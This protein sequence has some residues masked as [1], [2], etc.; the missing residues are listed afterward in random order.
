MAPRASVPETAAAVADAVLDPK[1][2]TQKSVALFPGSTADGAGDDAAQ[3]DPAFDALLAQAAHA[4]QVRDA[5]RGAGTERNQPRAL[6]DAAAGAAGSAAA[7]P[8]DLAAKAASAPVLPGIAQAAFERDAANALDGAALPPAAAIGTAATAGVMPDAD[9]GAGET[10][11]PRVGTPAWDNALGQKVV[12]MAAGAEQSASLTLNPP[13]LG[14]LQV[15]I[16]VSN[17]HA[18]ATFTAAQPEVRQA[19][20]AAMPR[21]KEMLAD[22]GISLG[23]TSVGAGP[24]DQGSAQARQQAQEQ[25]RRTADGRGPG[26]GTPVQ[27]VRATRISTSGNGLVDTFA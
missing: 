5:A 14:P 7:L 21:L 25:A 23:Q 10:L 17:T 1:L 26:D 13:D 11:A 2:A 18:E 8:A 15:V 9:K 24:P 22:A 20:E 6:P 4:T 16:N 12:W 3:S 27:P 19:L